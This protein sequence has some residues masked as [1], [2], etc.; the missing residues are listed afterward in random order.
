L[1]ENSQ[2]ASAEILMR[3]RYSA[4]ALGNAAYVL[5]TWHVSTRP[6]QLDLSQ[7]HGRWLGLTVRGHWP[8]GNTAEVEFE[9]RFKPN[10][11]GAAQ[12]LHERS[13]FV[14]EEGRWWYVDGQLF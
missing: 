10:G 1:A 9:A 4:Y 3:S 11:G 8:Q 2:A 12:R 13:G 6:Q 5:A 7:Q 14:L